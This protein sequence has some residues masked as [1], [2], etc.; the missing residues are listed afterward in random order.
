MALDA[1]NNSFFLFVA[2][3]I[4][5]LFSHRNFGFWGVSGWLYSG[6]LYSGWLYSGLLYSGLLYSGFERGF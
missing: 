3:D 6:W 5:V 4:E 2:R 1:K